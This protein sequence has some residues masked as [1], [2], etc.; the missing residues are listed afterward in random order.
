MKTSE[1]TIGNVLNLDEFFTNEPSQNIIRDFSRELYDGPQFSLISYEEQQFLENV[2]EETLNLCTYELRQIMVTTFVCIWGLRLSGFLFYRI[3]QIGRDKRFDDRRSNVIRFAVFWTFQAVWVFTVS[4]PVIFINSPRKVAPNVN[5]PPM[6][7]LDIVG[8]V[9]FVVGFLCES[10]SDIQK[11][12][13]KENSTTKDR[14]SMEIFSPPKLLWRNFAVVGDLRF[15]NECS[16]GPEWLAI[17]SP[18]FITLILLFLSG[19]PLLERSADER[20]R[21]IDDYRT[22]KLTTS[23][24]I[25]LPKGVYFDIPRIFKFLLFCEY[26]LYNYLDPSKAAPLPPDLP[27]PEAEVLCSSDF[28]D[29]ATKISCMR[30]I[31]KVHV[32][33]FIFIFFFVDTYYFLF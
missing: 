11:F 5:P 23:P 27:V 2:K 28:E 7:V 33:P 1:G 6:T 24:L 10:V 30:L 14:W 8:T 16:Q 25:P 3:L 21:N 29:K 20:Y 4:L 32:L 12:Q 17:L 22:Y 15:V 26:P 19:L 9:M 18:I 31:F 13:F